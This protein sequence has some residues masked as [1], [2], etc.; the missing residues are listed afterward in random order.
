MTDLLVYGAAE[1]VVGP[2][3]NGLERI[4]DGALAVE[5]GTVVATGESEALRS[6]YGDATRAIDASGRTV[7]P[8]FV[9]PHTHALFAGDRSDEFVARIEGN[10]YT[11]IMDKGGG[12]PVTVESVREASDEE[13]LANLLD[14]LDV[15]LEHGTTMAEV[16]S[17][18]GLDTETELRMLAVI[19][20]ADERHP[21]DVIPTF[22]G[23]HAV[24][25]E[26]ET[27]AYVD[28]VVEDQLPAVADQGIAAFCDV[29][30]E[31]GVFDVSQS[32][33]ILEA[34]QDH[35]LTPKIHAEE[36]NRIGGAQLAADLGAVSA[37]HLLSATDDD[38]G[39]LAEAG[40]VPTLLP[41][42]AFSL[43]EPYADAEP[44]LDAGGPVALG[45]DLNPSCF[46]HSMGM[47]VSLA[48]LRMKLSP[49]QA[50]LGATTHAASALDRGG[51]GTLSEGTPADFTVFDL[52]SVTHIPANAGTNR[53]E[54]VV[55][56]GEPVVTAGGDRR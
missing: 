51:V 2:G 44:F 20:E 38:A 7:L 35:G 5:D 17:G 47:V 10:S 46:V 9:D 50:I 3:E 32:R 34:G 8:G 30:C 36:F 11:D 55:K 22:M 14:Q 13:L 12:I 45:T 18:Y 24:P 26:M 28:V 39:A 23:A 29:F 49:A 42:T 16:K 54:T 19:D 15:M 27:D 25:A 33:R 48:C 56:D 53:V 21:V 31:E 1:L 4:E 40:V 43:D 37:D 6:E 41:A 52:P